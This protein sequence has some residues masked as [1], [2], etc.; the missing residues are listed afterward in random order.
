MKVFKRFNVEDYRDS[1][2]HET[3][4]TALKNFHLRSDTS[5]PQQQQQQQLEQEQDIPWNLHCWQP[6]ELQ[7]TFKKNQSAN[8]QEWII[9][10]ELWI[11]AGRKWRMPADRSSLAHIK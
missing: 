10:S 1:A 3:L 8:V 5:H 2:S 4:Q 9:K 11:I 6:T 7:V